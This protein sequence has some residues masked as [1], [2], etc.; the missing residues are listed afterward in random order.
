MHHWTD[1]AH[2]T[3]RRD[4]D[5]ALIPADP[6]NRDFARIDPATIRAYAPDLS[7]ERAEAQRR[8][9]DAVARARAR[10]DPF[11]DDVKLSEAQALKAGASEDALILLAASANGSGRTMQEEADAVIA[12]AEQYLAVI[13]ETERIRLEAARK[14][15][16]ADTSEAI[17]AARAHYVSVLALL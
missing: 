5:G 6:A 10:P 13:A 7:Q 3:V 16:A 8:I 14:I 9:A 4:G 15:A 12:K 2:T 11:V 1:A 17:D